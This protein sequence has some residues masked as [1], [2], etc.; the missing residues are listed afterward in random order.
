M[1]Y[2]VKIDSPSNEFMGNPEYKDCVYFYRLKIGGLNHDTLMS[3]LTSIGKFF[4]NTGGSNSR[5]RL[6]DELQTMNVSHMQQYIKSHKDNT[7][8]LDIRHM[9]S[10]MM[11]RICRVMFSW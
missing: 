11:K 5:S 8:T 1:I 9:P 10:P 7:Y 4:P 2:C 3:I 6:R